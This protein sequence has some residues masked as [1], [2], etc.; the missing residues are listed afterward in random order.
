MYVGDPLIGPMP[1]GVDS[2]DEANLI[3]SKYAMILDASINDALSVVMDD[4]KE[5]S[6]QVLLPYMMWK[7]A[8][9]YVLQEACLCLVSYA[10]YMVGCVHMAY[11]L[12][13]T[14]VVDDCIV[15]DD[16]LDWR[17]EEPDVDMDDEKKVNV[18][19]AMKRIDAMR[20]AKKDENC[21]LSCNEALLD[22]LK[23]MFE[24]YW[25]DFSIVN[26][27]GDIYH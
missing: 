15:D 27:V 16:A 5:E 9:D 2:I 1:V 12:V 22:G 13:M 10:F 3:N 19:R 25:T 18:A 7:S 26:D 8:M 17:L 4:V 21:A 20:D 11:I 24:E 14:P 23:I 6:C